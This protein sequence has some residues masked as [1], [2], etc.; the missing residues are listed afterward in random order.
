MIMTFRYF[1]L[2]FCFLLVY[3]FG[4]TTVIAKPLDQIAAIVDNEIIT[5]SELEQHKKLL[6]TRIDL[7]NT[8]LPEDKILKK[9]I[10]NQMILDRLQLQL[11][12]STGI[13]ATTQETNAL[14]QTITKEEGMPLA[15]F[16]KELQ[17]KGV[18]LEAFRN[19]LQQELTIDKL[20]QREIGR[21]IVISKADVDGFL[22]SPIG[23]DQSGAEYKLQHILLSFPN[24]PTPRVIATT[25]KSAENILANLKNGADFTKTA[26]AKSDSQQALNGGNL[27]WRRIGN[28]PTIFI[29][30]VPNM[31]L[32]EIV[33]PI[34]S[35]NGFHIIKLVNKRIGNTTPH[36][37]THVRQI[38]IKPSINTSDQEARNN[39]IKIR[40]QILK[41]K[42]FANLAERKSEELSTATKGGG[43]GWLTE[44]AVLPKFYKEMQTLKNGELSQP[45]KTELGWHLIQVLD[46][47]SNS[48]SMDAARNRAKEILRERKYQE[49]LES[50]LKRLKNNAKIEIL[51]YL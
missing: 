29:K 23:Q 46:R 34:Q 37:E 32:N 36:I 27:G 45:F 26:M 20:R 35:T 24:N 41:G 12:N 28:I 44:K 31:Q 16:R 8:T 1:H 48:T 38:L 5:N 33:G 51:L 22:N 42:D 17:N 7:N 14:I 21:E 15:A 18:S 6:L 4:S 47:R 40:E 25:K 30:Y 43:L 50:W 3:L 39:L 19:H 11:A 2:L 49:L 10:L 9:Q 13:E